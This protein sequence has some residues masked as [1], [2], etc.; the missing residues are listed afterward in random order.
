MKP[1]TAQPK[2]IPPTPPR[3]QVQRPVVQHSNFNAA[4]ARRRL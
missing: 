1:I 3:N 2:P 4:T